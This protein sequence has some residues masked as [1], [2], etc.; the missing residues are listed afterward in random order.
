MNFQFF[1]FLQAKKQASMR[2]LVTKAFAHV[3]PKDK[4]PDPFKESK[5]VYLH[6]LKSLILNVFLIMY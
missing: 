6:F 4:M 3:M 2:W 5:K 1:L